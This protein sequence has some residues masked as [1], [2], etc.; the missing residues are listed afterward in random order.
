ML[1]CAAAA[2]ALVA[3]AGAAPAAHAAPAEVAPAA[4]ADWSAGA[5]ALGTGFTQAGG[6]QRVREVQRRLGRLGYRPGPADGLF[7][8]R[9]ERAAQRFQERNG[10]AADAVVGSRT[11][12]A[13]RTSDE[14]VRAARAERNA[15][16]PAAAQP[17]PIAPPTPA[18]RPSAP[19]AQPGGGLSPE[20]FAFL[21]A[22]ILLGAAARVR[23]RGREVVT[24]RGDEI[25][26]SSAVRE[27]VARSEA[28]FGPRFSRAEL[29]AP[30]VEERL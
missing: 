11:L 14:A 28:G 1:A 9:T 27:L 4:R 7:G 29:P 16:A 24:V 19:I 15:P 25:V 17:E 5:V 26:A 20:L 30:V 22:A 3:A 23:R 21:F 8:P 12:R 6:S 18:P 10:L 2:L 13:L